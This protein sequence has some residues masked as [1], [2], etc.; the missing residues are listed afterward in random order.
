MLDSLAS[1][2]P[3]L[4]CHAIILQLRAWPERKIAESPEISKITPEGLREYS[5]Y[6]PN[7]IPS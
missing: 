1:A 6:R 4:P 7:D 2:T 3:V 5:I